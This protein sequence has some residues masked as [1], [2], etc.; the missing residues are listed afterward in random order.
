MI[1]LC[2]TAKC[3][4]GYLPDVSDVGEVKAA[5]CGKEF[6]AAIAEYEAGRQE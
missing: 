6:P 1:G 4:R 5:R 3:L 2:K